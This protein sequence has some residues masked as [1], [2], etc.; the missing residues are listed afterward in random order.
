MLSIIFVVTLL[1]LAMAV[2]GLLSI[3]ASLVPALT[4]VPIG[5]VVSW[6]IFRA[7]REQGKRN[8]TL[9]LYKDY[10]SSDFAEKRVKAEKFFR[11]NR[12]SDWAGVDPYELPD[13][14]EWRDGYSAVA[15][16]FHRVAVLYERGELN[17]D[18]ASELLARELGYWFAVAFLP[19]RKRTDWW[20]RD[21]IYGLAR[22]F[23]TGSYRQLFRRGYLQ[24]CKSKRKPPPQVPGSV[25]TA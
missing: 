19:M 2:G 6:S 18:L 23:R 10:Y 12:R 5:G 16:Y 15:R 4:S 21:A 1:A 3:G 7:N 14:E 8:N 24:G 17:R 11:K 22:E 13:S 9:E 20:T 25:V